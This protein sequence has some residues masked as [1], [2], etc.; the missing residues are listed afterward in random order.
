MGS[1]AKIV[2][3]VLAAIFA[4][5]LLLS[6]ALILNQTAMLFPR[7]PDGAGIALPPGSRDLSLTTADGTRLRGHLVPGT[8]ADPVLILGFGGNGWNAR[9]TALHLH[10]AFPEQDVVAFHYRGYPPSQGSPSA[11][12][13]QADAVAILDSLVPQGPVVAVGISLGAGIAAHLAAERP[14]DGVILLTAFE[15]LTEVARDAFPL[16]PVRLFFRHPMDTAASLNRSDV[17][18]A[19]IS[20]SDDRLVIP[21]RTEA[22]RR[23]LPPGRIVL[24]VT[25]PGGHD[26]IHGHPDMRA[27]LRAALAALPG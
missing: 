17:P 23:A 15:S 12:A 18:V 6:V 7:L 9:A 20:A 3:P 2:L 4:G 14:L 21:A 19:L 16:A 1:A 11:A 25:L 26:S 22:L 13:V 8:G 5:W 27:T 24:D 10:H